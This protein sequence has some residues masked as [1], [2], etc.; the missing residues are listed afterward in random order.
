MSL[1]PGL[2]GHFER[3]VDAQHTAR[4]LG[5]GGVQGL[6][7]PTLVLWLEEAAVLATN[8]YL[9]PGQATVGTLVNIRHLAATPVGMTVRVRAE[10]TAID[11]RRLTFHVQAEDERERISEG[12]HE[13][14]IIDLTRFEARLASKK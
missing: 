10:L 7:T 2:S 8:A 14:F 13:R 9:E 5:S 3:V 12:T 6:A 4:H 1:T 11:G